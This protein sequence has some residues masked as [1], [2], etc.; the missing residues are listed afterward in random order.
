MLAVTQNSFNKSLAFAW[1]VVKD[2]YVHIFALIDTSLFYP[3]IRVFRAR[4]IKLFNT[5]S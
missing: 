1:M 5:R 3:H 4:S 2:L